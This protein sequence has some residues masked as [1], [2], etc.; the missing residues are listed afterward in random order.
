MDL[1]KAF[2]TLNHQILLQKINFYGIGGIAL[3]WFSSYLTGRQQFVEF[4]G[5][6]PDSLTLSTAVP[7][8]SILGPLLFLIYMNGIPSSSECFKYIL[9]ADDTTLFSTIQISEAIPKD[10]NKHLAE[11]YNWLAVNKLSLN[12][13]KSKYIVFHAVN[14]NIEGRLPELKIN[15]IS[16]ER[17][18][19]FNFLGL[20]LNE[21][22]LEKPYRYCR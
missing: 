19:N 15:D 22:I 13:K 8:G 10:L 6:Q 16:I 3:E 17:V 11:L 4:D 20:N 9:Y 12:V 5:I 21:H 18:Q 2:D 7:Q 1:S 14:K